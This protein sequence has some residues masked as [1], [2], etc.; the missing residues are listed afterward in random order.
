MT[1]NTTTLNTNTKEEIINLLIQTDN[2]TF[3]NLCS[4]SHEFS[5][6]CNSKFYSERIY[7]ERTKLYY[8][9]YL[10]YKLTLGSNMKWKEFYIR[11]ANLDYYL[12]NNL[13]PNLDHGNLDPL[14]VRDA[15]LED[16]ATELSKLIN[17]YA[18][19]GKLF[20]LNILHDILGTLPDTDI[21]W[22]VAEKGNL[23]MVKWLTE[24]RISSPDTFIIAAQKG[25]LDIMEYLVE[26][27][28]QQDYQRA[29]IAAA[30]TEN[31]PA[32]YWI[33]D[34]NQRTPSSESY[35]NAIGSARFDIIE[36][37][38]DNGSLNQIRYS[39]LDDFWKQ[40]TLQEINKLYRMIFKH[41]VTIIQG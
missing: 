36:F 34:Y 11:I 17:V 39:I 27:D 28:P 13:L 7:H 33:Y 2:R 18:Y 12:S 35:S 40:K 29:S 6:V 30:E 21:V 31:L 5:D 16:F 15:I 20:E 3:V 41:N 10:Q 22:L 26:N 8:P 37:G 32:L 4:S 23:E 25:H 19:N 9:E 38:L 24:H 1:T 14:Y